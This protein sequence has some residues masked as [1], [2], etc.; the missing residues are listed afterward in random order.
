MRHGNALLSNALEHVFLLNE[1]DLNEREIFRNILWNQ[2]D[3]DIR[4][5]LVKC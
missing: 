2:F 4:A 1:F 5:V 3:R